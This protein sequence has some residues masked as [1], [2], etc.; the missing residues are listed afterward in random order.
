MPKRSLLEGGVYR[1]L[2]NLQSRVPKVVVSVESRLSRDSHLNDLPTRERRA[3]R[4]F[5]KSF[6]LVCSHNYT[7]RNSGWLKRVR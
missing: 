6:P 4:A 2:R 3:V 1:E 7:Q 5:V